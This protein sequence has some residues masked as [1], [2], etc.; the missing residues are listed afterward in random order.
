MDQVVKPQPAVSLW[1]RPLSANWLRPY[2]DRTST[3]HLTHARALPNIGPIEGFQ[4]SFDESHHV[5][6]H[7][8]ANTLYSK[9]KTDEYLWRNEEMHRQPGSLTIKSDQHDARYYQKTSWK[10]GWHKEIQT[11]PGIMF[12]PHRY[13]DFTMYLLTKQKIIIRGTFIQK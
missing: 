12:I 10:T 3:P 5:K 13:L 8:L 1:A 2:S 11:T 7:E 4:S 9:R 6:Q